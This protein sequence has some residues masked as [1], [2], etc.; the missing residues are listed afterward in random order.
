MSAI[1]AR[2]ALHVAGNDLRLMLRDRGALFWGFLGPFLFITFFGLLFRPAPPG[3][4]VLYLRDDGASTTLSTAIGLILRDG[5]IKVRPGPAP[6]GSYE[7]VVPSGAADSVAAGVMPRLVLHTPNDEPTSREQMLVAQVLRA[8]MGAF[9]GLGP[10]DVRA[11]LD[12][13][14]IRTRVTFEPAIRFT[15]RRIHLPRM[16]Y[17][18]QRVVPAYLIM[19][20]LMSLLTYGAALLVVERRTGQLQRVLVASITPGEIVLGKFV[21]RFVWAWMQIAVLLGVGALAYHI[22]FGAHPGALLAVLTAFALSATALGLLFA[23][24]FRSPEKAGGLGSLVTLAMAAL[25]GLWWPLEIVPPWMAKLAFLLPTG[26]AF[27]GLNR[28]MVLDSDLSQ[29]G[30]HVAVLTGTA[31]V[32]LPLAAKRL[33]RPR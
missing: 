33:P 13:T 2:A 9:L 8:K 5:G 15:E 7:L 12:T 19:F 23:T 16:S 24:L 4:T 32:C 28:I 27:D 21:S 17:G 11:T 29:V 6:K 22:R 20:L 18:F 25:G 30:K 10:E 14:A 1:D 3:P 31:L 26:W